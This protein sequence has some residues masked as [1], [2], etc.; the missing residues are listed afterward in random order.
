MEGFLPYYQVTSVNEKAAHDMNIIHNM[1]MIH[2]G[3]VEEILQKEI[4]VV[5]MK[6]L[7]HAGVYKNDLAGQR[8]FMRFIESL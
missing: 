1:N 4:G 7:E 3:N 6:V 5:F 2:G 8:A